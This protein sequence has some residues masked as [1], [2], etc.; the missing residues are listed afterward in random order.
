MD[1]RL[2]HRSYEDGVPS[3]LQYEDLTV[4]EILERTAASYPDRPALVFM[5]G[6]LTYREFQDQVNRLAT[7]LS[8]LGVEHGSRVAIDLPNLPQTVIAYFAVLRVGAVVVM[9]NPLYTSREVEHQWNDAGVTAAI[10]MDALYERKIKP[11]HEH[12]RVEH[13]IIASIPEYLRFPLNLLAPL[14]LKRQNPPLMAKVAAAEGVHHFRK[15]ISGTTA[16]PPQVDIRLDDIA[17][18]QYT[19]GTTGIAKGA[20]LTHRN[21]SAQA[22]QLAQWTTDIE[23]GQ[24]VWL[25]ALPYFHIYGLMVA[26][27][28]PIHVGG[29]L[30]LIPNPRDVGAMIKG[31]EKHRVTFFPGVPAM[32]NAINQHRGI[33]RADLSSVKLCNSG[34]A[35][36]PVDVLERFEELTG[37]RIVE[38]YGLTE[39]SP[40]THSNPCFGVRKL[41]SI[42]VPLPDTDSRIVDMDDGVT[43]MPQGQEGELILKGPQV[44]PGYWNQP[45]ATKEA[46]RDGWFYTGDLATMDE[47][48]YF[49]IVGRKKDMI[50]ASGY[51]IYPDEIDRVLM[52]HPAVLECATIG[53]P[54]RKRGETVKSFV[55]LHAGQSATADELTAYCRENLAAYKVP[56]AIEF[57]DSLPKSTVLKV[58]RRELRE[59]ELAKAK[60]EAE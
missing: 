56:R 48:G 6:R 2:W 29:A 43:D 47:D 3:S 41:G 19:G 10:V 26:M 18:L 31:T 49:R 11:V 9:T 59:E 57:R 40:V 28:L 54:D 14:K 60:S 12:L 53:V 33:E 5:N 8:R 46:I 1:E 44:M 24:E 34:S 15:L 55:V 25:G 38:G 37:A 42:G 36:L 13:Y 23:P 20:M 7:A 22:Q 17:M 30:I 45:E 32:Y 27:L 16:D 58:L 51:N 52:S 4:P 21:M 35:P 50:L 39:T